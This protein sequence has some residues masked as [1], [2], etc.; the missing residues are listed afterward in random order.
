MIFT[1]MEKTGRGTGMCKTKYSINSTPIIPVLLIAL[2]NECFPI[3]LS[4][5]SLFS[6]RLPSGTTAV[7]AMSIIFDFTWQN[8][9]GGW[10]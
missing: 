10:N 5:I 3:L 1:K 7:T 9:N 6:H 2:T 8:K 4:I